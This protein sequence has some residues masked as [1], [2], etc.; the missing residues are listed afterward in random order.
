MNNF[1]RPSLVSKEETLDLLIIKVSDKP[2]KMEDR[3]GIPDDLFSLA[4]ATPTWVKVI[5][6]DMTIGMTIDYSLKADLVIILTDE[7]SLTHAYN[8]SDKFRLL[9][10]LTILSGQVLDE[11]SALDH[12]DSIVLGNFAD[13]LEETLLDYNKEGIKSKYTCTTSTLRPYPSDI[14]PASY[15]N[16]TWSIVLSRDGFYRPID[17]IVDEILT[18]GTDFIELIT[19]DNQYKIEILDRI[20]ELDIIWF[21]RVGMTFFDN[22]QMVRT[23]IDSGLRYIIVDLDDKELQTSMDSLY[24]VIAYLHEY[25]VKISLMIHTQITKPDIE[26]LYDYVLDLYS[27]SLDSIYWLGCGKHIDLYDYV[28]LKVIKRDYDWKT[29]WGSYQSYDY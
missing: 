8:I 28:N 13:I 9:G 19:D 11:A 1:Y 24:H 21:S 17:D 14:I 12:S 23:S 27:R 3:Y 22:M 15:Y 26:V 25:D 2:I 20:R 6:V 7:F 5:L 29:R 10:K 16:Y 18:C 4:A